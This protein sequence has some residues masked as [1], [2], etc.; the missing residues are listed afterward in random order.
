MLIGSR[1]P[2]TT[3]FPYT[4]LFRSNL[5]FGQGPEYTYDAQS[6]NIRPASRYFRDMDESNFDFKGNFE[7]PVKTNGHD[8]KIKFGGSY[9]TKERNF[10]ETIVQY[11]PEPST[12]LYDGDI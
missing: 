12:A 5:R 10:N 3:L 2:R 6:N 4:T 8:S 7:I 11:K 9:V 1:A